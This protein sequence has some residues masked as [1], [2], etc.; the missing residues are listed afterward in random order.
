MPE[1]DISQF[2]NMTPSELAMFFIGEDQAE[3][4]VEYSNI[5]AAQKGY[6]QII[7]NEFYILAGLFI[8]SGYNRVPTR[9]MYWEMQE[10]C[11]CDIVSNAIRRNRFDGLVRFL[12]FQDNTKLDKDNKLT[13]KSAP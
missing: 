4:T 5:Y 2:S 12:H 11:H 9:I 6:H 8:L 3:V 7:K 1:E 13:Q 10:D